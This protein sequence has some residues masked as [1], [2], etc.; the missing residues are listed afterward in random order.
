M[1]LI[2]Q[3][4]HLYEQQHIVCIV[5]CV[6][7]E[8][9]YNYS[10]KKSSVLKLTKQFKPLPP[11]SLC[12]ESKSKVTR[13]IVQDNLLYCFFL[14][15]SN[16]AGTTWDS[17]TILPPRLL[18]VYVTCLMPQANRLTNRNRESWEV[19]DVNQSPMKLLS[20]EESSGDHQLI[21]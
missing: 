21:W 18:G 13:G 20:M 1:Q 17:P 7:K 6:K 16:S 11:S 5:L 8:I 14:Q 9:S 10:F 4:E 2:G 19:Q 3:R 15:S 12:L